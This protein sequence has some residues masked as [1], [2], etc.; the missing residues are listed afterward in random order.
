MRDFERQ[1]KKK[2]RSEIPELNEIAS[3]LAIEVHH[4]GE[5]KAHLTMG[6]FYRYYDLASLT[7]ILFSATAWMR[8]VSQSNFDLDLPVYYFLPWWPHR[9]IRVKDCMVHHAGLNWR[10]PFY[11]KMRG[12]RHFENRWPQLQKYLLAQKPV[13]KRRAVYGNLD[14]HLLGFVLEELKQKSLLDIWREIQADMQLEHMDF[15]PN[16]RFLHARQEYAPIVC[17][18][19]RKRNLQGEVH[20]PTAWSMAGIAPHAGLFSNLHDVGKWALT[21]RKALRGEPT[22]FGSSKTAEQFVRRQLPKTQGDWGYLFMKPSMRDASCGR[23][24]SKQSFGHT[25]FTGTSI[26]M[27]PAKDLTVVILGN[28][29]N[30]THENLAFAKLRPKLHDWIW[31]LI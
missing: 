15:H 4:K 19:W 29:I 3:S 1:L 16:N 13:K 31:E 24:F 10:F 25:G 12:P 7:K 30:P 5:I 2:I 9:R 20:D 6:E 21:L 11:K 26:W 23:H 8:W 28:R 18:D 22:P 17:R 14:L 27:D